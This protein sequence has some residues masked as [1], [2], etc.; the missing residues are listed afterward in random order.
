MVQSTPHDRPSLAPDNTTTRQRLTR[1]I[2][3][4]VLAGLAARVAAALAVEV[5][6]RRQGT[7]CLFADTNIYWHLARAIRDGQ[8][9]IV[10][11]YD[12]P[13]HALRTPGYPLFLAAVSIFL[14]G[15][16]LTARFAQAALGALSIWLAA[17]L[18]ETLARSGSHT[19]HPIP[20]APWTAWL[21]ALEPYT[22]GMSALLLSEAVFVPLMLAGL[23]GIARLT[24]PQ[25]TS[26]L[27]PARTLVLALATGAAHGA[28]ILVRPSWAVLPPLAAVLA[29][30]LAGR[31]QHVLALRTIATAA[32]GLAIVMS[33][34]WARNAFALGRFVPTALWLG[35]SLYDGLNPHA[36]GSSDMRF[37]D[38]PD[39]RTLDELT[40]DQTLR[41][42]ALTYA[43]Q[44]PLRAVQLAASKAARFWSPWPQ[45]E[46]F[47]SLP[48]AIASA[49][50][51][52]PLYA[53]T[54][55]GAWDRR[56]EPVTLLVLLGPLIV[57]ALLHLV[58]VS[59]I[60]YRVPVQVPALGLAGFALARIQSRIARPPRSVLSS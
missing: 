28:A 51:V 10:S 49:L 14:G 42:R 21:V 56:R 45:A 24:S 23:L 9:Y 2:A 18:V 25:A 46:G 7:L 19:H 48:V 41:A 34:W 4:A 59:S 43:R 47:A 20:A 35:A 52:L 22:V 54:V 1:S 58:F 55:L 60:R 8:P 6:A 17:R 27:T 30:A 26:P 33:P 12:I 29:F 53:L 32:L 11:Q 38:E 3:L 37:L 57:F 31:A 5:V 44:H 50:I 39:I 36:N 16:T 13:H 15:S 40:Q